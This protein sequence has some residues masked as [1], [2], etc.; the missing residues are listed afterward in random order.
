MEKRRRK[1]Q[2]DFSLGWLGPGAV[3]PM[4]LSALGAAERRYAV[5]LALSRPPPG[6]K[7]V[8]QV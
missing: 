4:S 6:M 3:P 1:A 5:S 8:I 2:R 7:P